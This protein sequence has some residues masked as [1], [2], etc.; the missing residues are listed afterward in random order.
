MLRAFSL[1][2]SNRLIGTSSLVLFVYGFTLASTLPFQS[3]IGISELGLSNQAFALFLVFVAIA[4]VVSAV[5][6]GIISDSLQRRKLLLIGLSAA[7]FVGYG[8]IYVLHNAAALIFCTLTFIP[9]ALSTYSLLFANVRRESAKLDPVSAGSVT[10]IVRSIYALSWVLIPGG[11]AWWLTSSKTML[12]VYLVA[13]L[14]SLTC[15]LIYATLAPD[16]KIEAA[17]AKLGFFAA[18]RQLLTVPILIR[19]TLMALILGALR[20]NAT[21]MPLIV[22]NLHD[23][24]VRDV[25]FIAGLVP[26]FEVPFMLMWGW[27]ATRIS[28]EKSLM[29]GAVVFAIYLL[30]LSQVTAIWQVYAL[31]ILNGCGAAAL[32]SLPIAYFQNL[33]AD[34]PG[35]STALAPV[36]SFIANGLSA[37]VFAIGTSFTNYAGTIEIAG[38]L[39]FSGVALLYFFDRKLT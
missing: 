38:G 33:I 37:A 17:S 1:I 25:G 2:I 20:L 27:L 21:A 8:L 9:L 24:S 32:L 34:R 3:I 22:T 14:A 16:D 30:A 35:L 4:N 18:L 11:V 6:L 15:V 39:C 10:S 29:A 28:L 26:V 7:G 31:S 5:T 13:A 12:P 36:N 23:G 19:L